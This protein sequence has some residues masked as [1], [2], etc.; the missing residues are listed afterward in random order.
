MDRI[1]IK[2]LILETKIGVTEEERAKP[3]KLSFTI[4]VWAD[5]SYPGQTDLFESTLSYAKIKKWIIQQSVESRCRLLETLGRNI[6]D[7][8][9]PSPVK[10]IR[11]SVTIRKLEVWE[12]GVP[13]VTICRRF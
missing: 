3:Q 13:S 8:D 9:F 11:A 6:L 1:S 12:N 4:T 10:L 5:L 7:F 2:N